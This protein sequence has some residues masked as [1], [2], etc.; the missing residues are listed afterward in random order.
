MSIQ[1]QLLSRFCSAHFTTESV[2]DG[3]SIQIFGPKLEDIFMN[4]RG[5]I[6][7]QVQL[8]SGTLEKI[9]WEDEAGNELISSLTNVQGGDSIFRL[10][11]DI[12]Y[13]EWSQGVKRYCVVEHSKSLEPLKKLYERK[14][15]KVIAHSKL[16]NNLSCHST[17]SVVA[18]CI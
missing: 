8:Q 5:Q 1:S 11:L 10:P 7:C 15:G 12:T 13:D 16:V 17:S 2:V 14:I 9:W 18:I 3:V 4:R 6:V